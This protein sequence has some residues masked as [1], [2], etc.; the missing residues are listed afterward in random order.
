MKAASKLSA[1]RKN[2]EIVQDFA[3]ELQGRL[4]VEGSLAGVL[5]N[6][7]KEM[8]IEKGLD[9]LKPILED[10]VNALGIEWET[11]TDF[12]LSLNNKDL[13]TAV[14]TKGPKQFLIEH[15]PEMVWR[16]LKDEAENDDAKSL[17]IRSFNVLMNS[18]CFCSS[19]RSSERALLPPRFSLDV[20]VVVVF[21]RLC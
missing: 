1:I 2:P 7:L 17:C 6:S 4:E 8:A 13:W 12:A 11:F 16:L 14:K 20:D 19:F 5:K 9:K 10:P 18:V 21:S 3:K 15:Q